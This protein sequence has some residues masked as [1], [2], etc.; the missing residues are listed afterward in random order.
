MHINTIIIELTKSIHR[1]LL[2][3]LAARGLQFKEGIV[4]S[5]I[6]YRLLTVENNAAIAIARVAADAVVPSLV[7]QA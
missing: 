4:G 2:T 1:A 5:E 3:E 7:R 6:A